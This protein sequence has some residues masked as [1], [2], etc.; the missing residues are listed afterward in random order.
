MC[1]FIYID[2]TFDPAK[3]AASIVKHD[4]SLVLTAELDW[5]A[6]VT[7]QDVRREYNEDRFKSFVPL[8]GRLHAVGYVLRDGV[9]RIISLRKSNGR[10][11]DFYERET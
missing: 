2:S 3:N 1:M 8:N 5:A 6:A 11:V 9:M 10:E 7:T 4:V